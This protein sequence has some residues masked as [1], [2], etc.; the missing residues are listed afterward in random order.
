MFDIA[1]T[2]P[3]IALAVSLA[4]G[5]ILGPLGSATHAAGTMQSGETQIAAAGDMLAGK[6]DRETFVLPEDRLAVT[7]GTPRFGDSD[8]AGSYAIWVGEV[9]RNGRKTVWVELIDDYGEVIYDSEVSRNETHLLPD[10]RA[11][12][13]R[14]L[15]D[16]ETPATTVA[17]TDQSRVAPDARLVVTRRVVN[18][19]AQQTEI[20]F[21]E[22]KPIEEPSAM[23]KVAAFGQM[24][25]MKIVASMTA[26]AD[27]VMVAWNWIT[28]PFR[29]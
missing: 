24:I 15:E 14:A 7:L 22:Q 25:W 17:K 8:E 23:M 28:E 1:L 12:A 27:S 26:A 9:E 16:P 3:R 21:I 20:E 11:I 4:S 19:P 10:G 5:M 6:G 2:A 29:A 18:D 13:V